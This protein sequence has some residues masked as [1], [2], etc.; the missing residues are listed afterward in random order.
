MRVQ[1]VDTKVLS[2]PS[3]YLSLLLQ[4]EGS[5]LQDIN[6][7][8]FSPE[9]YNAWIKAAEELIAEPQ[10]G[11]SAFFLFSTPFS[12]THIHIVPSFPLKLNRRRRKKEN[13]LEKR[14][15]KVKK[16][17]LLLSRR[18]LLMRRRTRHE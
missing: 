12:L 8:L 16:R 7:I 4:A 3:I 17:L 6:F 13:Q 11:K 1:H 10:V 5:S 18:W 14:E 15:N 9:I 2:L